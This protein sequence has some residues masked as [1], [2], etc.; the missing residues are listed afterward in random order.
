M[1]RLPR[2]YAPAI[3][4]HVVQRPADGRRL[5]VDADDYLFFTALLADAV[6]AH[7]VAL[8]AYVLLPLQFRLLATPRDAEAIA[9]TVQAVG[10]SY[11]P[12]LNRRTGSLGPLWGHRYRSTLVD[13]DAFLIPSMQFVERQPVADA[14]VATPDQW[15]WSS[16]G[17]H[18]GHEQQPF[19]HDHARYWALSDT[20][21]ER[22][23]IY[24]ALAEAPADAQLDRRIESA[25]DHGWILG[26]AAFVASIESGLNRRGSPL[27]RGRP[28]LP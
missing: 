5:F 23:A 15:R 25:A 21:F 7:G 27:P 22:Q 1:A 8:H 28:R 26:D 24:R 6:R 19:L 3:V 10:R 9:R 12:H 20:P 18:A 2:L 4:Q 14:M 17:H 16:H 11:V 13:A